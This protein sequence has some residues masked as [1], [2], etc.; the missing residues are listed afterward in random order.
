MKLIL[1]SVFKKRPGRGPSGAALLACTGAQGPQGAPGNQ[2]NPGN[3]GA[4][5]D[6]G[7]PGGQGPEGPPG[8]QGPEGPP[9]GDPIDARAEVQ[10]PGPA[11]YPE[12]IAAASDGALY[13][14]SIGTGAIGRFAPGA[15]DSEP[16]L[17]SRAAFGVYGMA[18]DEANNLL[19]ACT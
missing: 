11:F 9:G 18:V 17:A 14:G 3:P 1:T 19:W 15:I 12:G 5:G 13:V 4:P 7:P 10:L 2:G 6:Q 16:F 8:G